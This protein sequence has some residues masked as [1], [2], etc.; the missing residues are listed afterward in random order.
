MNATQ[1]EPLVRALEVNVANLSKQIDDV[2][3][4]NEK[5]AEHAQQLQSQLDKTEQ[6]LTDHITHVEKWD[7]RRWTTI[8]FF[9]AGLITLTANLILLFVKGK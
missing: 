3:R 7:A 4:L 1:I 9:V 2:R 5:L 8:G 6:K